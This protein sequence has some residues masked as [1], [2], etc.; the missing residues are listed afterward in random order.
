MIRALS[1]S[2]TLVLAL[3]APAGAG[4]V[5]RLATDEKVVALTF[6]ACEAG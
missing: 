1:Y 6:D 3:A 5:K 2:L 4:V